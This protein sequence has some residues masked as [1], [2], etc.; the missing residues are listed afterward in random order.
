MQQI[1]I[2]DIIAPKYI[3]A[4]RDIR[5]KGENVSNLIHTI[6]LKRGMRNLE[7]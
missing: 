3:E 5:Y 6:K 4:N 2:F 1:Y 7:K